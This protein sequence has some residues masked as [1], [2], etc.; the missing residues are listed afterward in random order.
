VF[1]L[2]ALAPSLREDIFTGRMS[3]SFM[4]FERERVSGAPDP[5]RL[6]ALRE[7]TVEHTRA[8]A[9]IDGEH[10][11]I[12]SW[13]EGVLQALSGENAAELDRLAAQ[14]REEAARAQTG[15]EREQARRWLEFVEESRESA[16]KARDERTLLYTELRREK[17]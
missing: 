14:A 11:R 17:R 6:K 1:G 16:R 2:A 9:R 7:R 4:Q 15:A 12:A 10:E 8:V 3:F 5:E 13:Y